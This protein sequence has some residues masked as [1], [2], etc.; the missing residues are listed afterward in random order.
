M[1]YYY[2]NV[3]IGITLGSPTFGAIEYHAL[4][5]ENS[6]VGTVLDIPQAEVTTEAGD[7]VTLELVNNNG[8]FDI[9]PS[10]VEG[11]A[12]FKISVSFHVNSVNIIEL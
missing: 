9:A 4:L 8:T 10:V 1:V 3:F 2:I 12:R 7:V 11:F 5:D 6:P